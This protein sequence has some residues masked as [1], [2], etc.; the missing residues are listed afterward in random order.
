[1]PEFGQKEDVVPGITTTLHITPDRIGTFPVICTELCGLGHA[2]MRSQAI[3]MEP[4]AFASW[5]KQQQKATQPSTSSGGTSAAAGKAVFLNNACGSCHT[6]T[7]AGATATIGPDLD[8][9]PQWAR[10]ARQP[11]QAFVHQSIV[12]PNAYIQPG[13]PKNLM[14]QTF[15]SS[16]SKSELA[17]LIQFLVSSSKKG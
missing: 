16:L 7:A 5:A 12:D 4:A 9:L 6:L 10:Q 14:P 13:Y 8:K 2:L 1:V 15:G 17:S 3:E 11:L